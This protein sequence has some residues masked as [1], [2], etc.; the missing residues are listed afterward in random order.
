MDEVIKVLVLEEVSEG[1]DMYRNQDHARAV[2][3]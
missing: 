3:D 2:V 1:E